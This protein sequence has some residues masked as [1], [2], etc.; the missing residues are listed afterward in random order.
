[1]PLSAFPPIALVYSIAFV[2]IVAIRA[3]ELLPI[4]GVFRPALMLSLLS[5]TALVFR[6]DKTARSAALNDISTKLCAAYFGWAILS[7]PFSQ[8]PKAA[9][10]F[11]LTTGLP[12]VAMLLAMLLSPPTQRS[13]DRLTMGFVAFASIHIIGLRFTGT[14]YTGRLVGAGALDSNDLASLAAMSFPLAISLILRFKGM[15]RLIGIG[16][17]A[18]SLAGM[19]WFN[20]RGGTLAML[21]GMVTLIILQKGNR[22][23]ALAGLVLVGGTITWFSASQDYRDRIIGIGNLD[24]D[25]NVT[26]YNGRKQ[27][28][29]RGRGY[30]ASYPFAGV[31]ANQF[32]V[33]EGMTL[34][35]N[36]LHGKW[37]AAHNAYIQAFAELGIP[38]GLIFV[39]VLGVGLTRA[40]R[41]AQP[42]EPPSTGILPHPEYLASLAAFAAGAY[43]LSHAYFY[44]LFALTGMISLAIGVNARQLAAATGGGVPLQAL[45]RHGARG[46]AVRR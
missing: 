37:S 27:V 45:P 46:K 13:I 33:M 35:A 42:R 9:M 6:A 12:A 20:S 19:V 43:F 8:W 32:S 24:N 4:L 3:H 31:G 23:W 28:W 2:G 25:Y 22:R 41:L 39:A 16:G 10:M 17:T 15:P 7:S 40:R 36:G 26:D 11:G 14:D 38:G 18:M 21:A 29:A 44:A 34:R 1:V 30:I 5:L